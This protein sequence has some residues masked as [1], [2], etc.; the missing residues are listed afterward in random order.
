MP[1][2]EE[3]Q[4]EAM[5]VIGPILPFIYKIVEDATDLYFG[6]GYSPAVRA[7]HDNRAMGS[8]IFRHAETLLD[9]RIGSV[10]GASVS[11]YRGLVGLSYQGRAVI[12]PKMVSPAGRHRNFA[13][14]QQ[15][16]YAYQIPLPG[17]PTTFRLTAGY[18]LD[19]FN[20]RVERI[21][22]ARPIGRDVWWTSQVIMS[23][24]IA[25]WEDI[26]PPG[27]DGMDYVDFDVVRRSRKSHGPR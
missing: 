3:D 23:E 19:D 13:T 26:T 12:R 14:A 1:T 5:E 20:T 4:A 6:S 7:Q 11:R 27:F 17:F 16:D 21:M 10:K 2:R 8:C 25:K 15:L 22:I 24:E 9:E 18:Q